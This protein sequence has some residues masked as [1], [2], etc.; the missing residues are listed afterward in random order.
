MNEAAA[1][2]GSR[3]MKKRR[4][5]TGRWSRSGSRT[6]RKRT[7]A[8]EGGWRSLGGVWEW[9]VGGGRWGERARDGVGRELVCLGEKQKIKRSVRRGKRG[10]LKNRHTVD[11][12][13]ICFPCPFFSSSNK[14]SYL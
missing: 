5:G 8:V 11:S 10:L 1:G 12:R 13:S 4:R 9:R 7:A 2:S 14:S 6:R 3:K